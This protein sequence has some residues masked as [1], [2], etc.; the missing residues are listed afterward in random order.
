M[1]ILG[2][3]DEMML[4]GKDEQISVSTWW[5]EFG[6]IDTLDSYG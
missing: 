3:H 2:N 1:P 6:G 5:M 4:Q